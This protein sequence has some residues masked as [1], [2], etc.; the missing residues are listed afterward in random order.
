MR[1]AQKDKMNLCMGNTI[2]RALGR[3]KLSKSSFLINQLSVLM[4]MV[5]KEALEVDGKRAVL[6]LLKADGLDQPFGLLVLYR[7]EIAGVVNAAEIYEVEG[8]APED[9]ESLKVE[10]ALCGGDVVYHSALIGEL[11]L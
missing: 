4:A 3:D 9:E 11:E 10:A 2:K 1:F 5:G 6:A 8:A 7:A